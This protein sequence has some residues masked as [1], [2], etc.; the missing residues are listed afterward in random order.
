MEKRN[1][2]GAGLLKRN[3]HWQRFSSLWK[4][5]E[6]LDVNKAFGQLCNVTV[7]GVDARRAMSQGRGDDFDIGGLAPTRG[8]NRDVFSFLEN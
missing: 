2:A 6:S 4:R 5:W 1:P 7:F 3:G 8:V